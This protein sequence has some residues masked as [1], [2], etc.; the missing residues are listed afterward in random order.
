M[1][2]Y[3][4]RG[5]SMTL[6]LHHAL[7]AAL[8]GAPRL[9]AVRHQWEFLPTG[10]TDEYVAFQSVPPYRTLSTG[11]A[12]RTSGP[13]FMQF[14][15]GLQRWALRMTA[16][17]IDGAPRGGSL[18][19]RVGK[20]APRLWRHAADASRRVGLTIWNDHV[21]RRRAPRLTQPRSQPE[22]SS[23]DAQAPIPAAP[24]GL[25]YLHHN[26]PSRGRARRSSPLPSPSIASRPRGL[27]GRLSLTDRTKL[28]DFHST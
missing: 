23:L 26:H 24:G 11:R 15:R 4:S 25:P 8:S 20:D 10:K 9:A 6:E 21:S 18:A 5:W 13:V 3:Y 12:H 17:D 28:R 27:L 1:T 14:C 19:D 22:R 7:K 2:T 16:Y